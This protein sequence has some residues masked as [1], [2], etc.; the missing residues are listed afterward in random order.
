MPIISSLVNTGSLLP[1]GFCIN[2]TPALLWLYVISDA[3]IVLAYYSIPISLA[4]FVRHRKDL[5]FSWVF[6]LFGAF[7]LACG[8]THLLGIVT[9]WNPIYWVDAGMKGITAVI[10]LLTAVALVWQIRMH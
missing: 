1:H 6:K 5:Q 7:I 9:L 10:S 2:W 8:T 4:Y 3:L